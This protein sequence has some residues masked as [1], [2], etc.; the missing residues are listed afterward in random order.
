MIVF[1]IDIKPYILL[2]PVGSTCNPNAELRQ[3]VYVDDPGDNTLICLGDNK[4]GVRVRDETSENEECV[5]D[6]VERNDDEFIVG[7]G[8]ERNEE[9]EDNKIVGDINEVDNNNNL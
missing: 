8:V 3:L 1:E 5:G 7:D 2:P 6:E 9:G 4:D